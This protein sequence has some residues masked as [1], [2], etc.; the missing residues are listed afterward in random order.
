MVA[1]NR[2]FV[3]VDLEKPQNVF[4]VR[5]AAMRDLNDGEII[6]CYSAN[7]KIVVTQKCITEQGSFYRTN[8]A[9]TKRL[10]WAFE[11]SA[12][13]LPNEFAPPRPS[14]SNSLNDNITEDDSQ[15]PEENKKV[16]SKI[17][18]ASPKG[19]EESSE[20]SK[21]KKLFS[22]KLFWKRKK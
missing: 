10:D 16:I 18:T 9:K 19:G 17:E 20:K 4:T 13:G 7:T 12:F 3:W 1:K 14:L 22:F 21:T 2:I 15:L 11:A 6:Q 5:N 8:S